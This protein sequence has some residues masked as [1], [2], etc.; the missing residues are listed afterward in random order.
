MPFG[1]EKHQ[2]LF[3]VLVWALVEISQHFLDDG[4]HP[5]SHGGPQMGSRAYAMSPASRP[6][7]PFPGWGVENS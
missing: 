4:Q 5:W 3:C 7:N 1:E 2:S 6:W